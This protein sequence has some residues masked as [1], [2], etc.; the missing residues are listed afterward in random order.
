M[1]AAKKP[2]VAALCGGVGGAK[3]ALGLQY[4]TPEAEL[5]VIVN[6][7]DDFEHLGLTIC[8]DLDTVMYTLAGVS[9]T[10]RGWGR[11]GESWA[12]MDALRA[13]G[14]D[15]WFRLGD[16][17]LATHVLRTEA[18]RAGHTLSEITRDLATALAVR[19]RIMPMSDDPVRTVITSDDGDLSFQRYFVK[20][21]AAPRVR[22]IRFSDADAAAA[23]GGVLEVLESARLAAVVVCPSNP[24]LS[25][26]PILGIAGIRE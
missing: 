10:Q 14:G 23:P 17:D 6:T 16:R 15:D 24:F 7:G 1:N 26:D 4:A 18:L 25:I 20:L 9:D 5:A 11:A 13:L 8:P 21:A 2:L 19:A 3:L 12:F 22:R